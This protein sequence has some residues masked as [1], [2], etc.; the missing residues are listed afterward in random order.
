[1][2]HDGTVNYRKWVSFLF[3]PYNNN[4]ESSYVKKFQ[5]NFAN[6]KMWESNHNEMLVVGYTTEAV[7]IELNMNISFTLMF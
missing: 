5:S 1:M 7:V 4:V 6:M 2:F 3:E